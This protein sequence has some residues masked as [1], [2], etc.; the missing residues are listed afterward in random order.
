MP[1]NL[2]QP[3][4]FG[5][6]HY[7]ALQVLVILFEVLESGGDIWV[8]TVVIVEGRKSWFDCGTIHGE[9][10]ITNVLAPT[11]IRLSSKHRGA[12]CSGGSWVLWYSLEDVVLSLSIHF[13][14]R[15]ITFNILN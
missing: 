1:L 11:E 9:T 15:M 10:R 7:C 12:D 13:Y 5:V 8:W 2:I 4:S 3:L 14:L 6:F